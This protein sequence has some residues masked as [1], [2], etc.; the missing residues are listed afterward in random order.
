[1]KSGEALVCIHA[2]PVLGGRGVQKFGGVLFSNVAFYEVTLH[3]D[4]F[5]YTDGSGKSRP[6]DNSPLRE[7]VVHDANI[8]TPTL[9]AYPGS[10]PETYLLLRRT[11][12]DLPAAPQL[13]S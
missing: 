11:P 9:R 1:M 12:G 4:V 2:R 8:V 3:A 7:I 6:F 5:G 10:P 13:P